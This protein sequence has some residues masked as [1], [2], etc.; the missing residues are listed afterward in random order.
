MAIKEGNVRKWVLMKNAEYEW[1]YRL[2]AALCMV[3]A[4]KQAYDLA[5]IRQSKDYYKFGTN[6]K[7]AKL[8]KPA[9]SGADALSRVI[10]H[11]LMHPDIHMHNLTKQYREFKFSSKYRHVVHYE[12]LRPWIPKDVY[13][14]VM[15]QARMKH[16]TFNTLVA[17]WVFSAR[18]QNP[19]AEPMRYL[20]YGTNPVKIEDLS[21]NFAELE[22]KNGVNM[23]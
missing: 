7:H 21:P 16:I 8:Y 6:L 17:Y 11:S 15:K 19:H 22:V 20:G 1:L 5:K 18:I 9:S 14:Q 4:P 2:S 10:H 3:L 13:L 12:G 23:G